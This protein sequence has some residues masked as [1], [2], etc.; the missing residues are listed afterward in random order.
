LQLLA[1]IGYYFFAKSFRIIGCYCDRQLGN[2]SDYDDEESFFI[3][4]II[5]GIQVARLPNFSSFQVNHA[6][7]LGPG[8]PGQLGRPGGS[9]RL[10]S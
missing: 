9:S 7:P 4:M 2:A 10:W 8:Q 6:N 5:T 1:I 3:I